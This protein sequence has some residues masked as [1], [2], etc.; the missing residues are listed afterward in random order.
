MARLGERLRKSQ[1]LPS[2]EFIQIIYTVQECMAMPGSTIP[3]IR[4]L[5]EKY[6]YNICPCADPEDDDLVDSK[7]RQNTRPCPKPSRGGAFNMDASSSRGSPSDGSGKGQS[8]R[9]KEKLKEARFVNGQRNPSPPSDEELGDNSIQ[10]QI[11]LL[12]EHYHQTA[13]QPAT[14]RCNINLAP[15]QARVTCPQTRYGVVDGTMLMSSPLR[16]VAYGPDVPEHVI[17]KSRVRM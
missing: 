4:T 14:V 8:L 13:K 5:R 12:Q 1:L 6:A 3:P 15:P 2:A 9:E 11:K 7:H 16:N 10:A 17:E